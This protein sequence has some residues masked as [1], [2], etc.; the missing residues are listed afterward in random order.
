MFGEAGGV[1]KFVLGCLVLGDMRGVSLFGGGK[2]RGGEVEESERGWVIMGERVQGSCSG[3]LGR[4]EV[5]TLRKE[6]I[7]EVFGCSARLFGFFWKG[8]KNV[9]GV[10]KAVRIGKRTR[11]GQRA[12]A[13]ITEVR[14]IIGC[15]NDIEEIVASVNCAVRI[16]EVNEEQEHV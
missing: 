3:V 13:R 6:K 8:A 11:R 5:T 1:A 9:E 4:R 15:K 10:C 12:C 16:C 14:S 2:R 7:M